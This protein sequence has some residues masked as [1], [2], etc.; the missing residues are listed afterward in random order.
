M[1]HRGRQEFM[2][3]IPTGCPHKLNRVILKYTQVFCEQNMKTKYRIKMKT[4][5]FNSVTQQVLL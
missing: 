2:E 4:K 5:N 3:D 1:C